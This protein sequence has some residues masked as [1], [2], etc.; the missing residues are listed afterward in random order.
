[1]KAASESLTWYV[2]GEKILLSSLARS[3]AAHGAEA[4]TR[5]VKAQKR[6]RDEGKG[7]APTDSQH[8]QSQH[9]LFRQLLILLLLKEL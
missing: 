3:P 1:M 4:L 6:L 9:I 2:G 7:S 5:L 8:V